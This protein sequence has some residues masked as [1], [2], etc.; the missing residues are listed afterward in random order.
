M[1]SLILALLLRSLIAPLYILGSIFLTVLTTL[2][3]TGLIFQDV[4]DFRYDGVDWTVPLMLFVIL[5]VLAADY[6][7]FL[8]S[9]VKEEAETYGLREGVERGV[10][11]SLAVLRKPVGEFGFLNPIPAAGA[12]AMSSGSVMLNS[13]RLR[14]FQPSAQRPT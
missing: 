7:I 8:M 3:V 1:A 10:T 2:A 6:S 11:A 4:L 13:L 12:M 9:R 14:G 5:V